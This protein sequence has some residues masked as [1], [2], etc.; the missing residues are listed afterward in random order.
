MVKQKTTTFSTC[1]NRKS[2]YFG[3]NKKRHLDY[4]TAPPAIALNDYILVW[5]V[6]ND[7]IFRDYNK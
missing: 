2:D 1:N 5:I 4:V 7:S 6:K 3:L